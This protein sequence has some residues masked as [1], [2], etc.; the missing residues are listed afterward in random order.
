MAK[1]KSIY[2]LTSA[3]IRRIRRLTKTLESALAELIELRRV[4]TF[5]DPRYHPTPHECDLIDEQS[6]LEYQLEFFTDKSEF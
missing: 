3:D 5:D 6:L 1:S 4:T 2:L